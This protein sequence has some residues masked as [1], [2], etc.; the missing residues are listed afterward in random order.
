MTFYEIN[1]VLTR[2]GADSKIIIIGDQIQTDLY[3]KRN[4]QSGMKDFLKVV[5]KLNNFDHITFNQHD[6]VRSAFVKSWICALEDSGV[7]A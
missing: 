3:R 4:D 6:I 1:S 5:Q 7:L 2:V